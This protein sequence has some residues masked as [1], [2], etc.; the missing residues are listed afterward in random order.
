MPDGV[1]IAPGVK[2]QIGPLTLNQE[3]LGFLRPQFFHLQREDSLSLPT[4]QH[5]GR[6]GSSPSAVGKARQKRCVPSQCMG[7]W[8]ENTKAQS[9]INSDLRIAVAELHS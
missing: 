3:E 6:V 5:L 9:N 2:L 8:V 7:R 4:C 1:T